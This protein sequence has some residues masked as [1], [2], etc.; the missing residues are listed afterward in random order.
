MLAPDTVIGGKYVIVRLLESGGM[1]DVYDAKQKDLGRPVAIKMLRADVLGDPAM[2]VR[3][4]R[5][6]EAAASLGHPN[7]VQVLDFR[8]DPDQPPMLI[9]EKLEGRSLRELLAEAG[10]L[11]PSRVAFIALQILSAL[12]AAHDAKIVH[13]DVKPA[14]IFILKTFAVRDFVKVLDFGVAKVLDPGSAAPVITDLGQVLGTASYMAPEQ[15]KGLQVDG[16][17]DLFAV[18]SILFEALSGRRPRELG[19]AGI[20]DVGMKPCLK[21]RDVAPSIDPLLA[22]VVDRALALDPKERFPTAEAMAKALAPFVPQELLGGFGGTLKMIPDTV[23]M[24]TGSEPTRTMKDAA[25][26]SMASAPPPPLRSAPLPPPSDPS[27][28]S[29][30]V[31]PGAVLRS[32]SGAPPERISLPLPSG[33]STP[34]VP[35]SHGHGP[36]TPRHDAPAGKSPRSALYAVVI[37]VAVLA[38][39]GA[40]GALGFVLLRLRGS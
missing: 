27:A 26:P 32:P 17:A 7:I 31:S 2:F 40:L 16:R 23:P 8:N 36:M 34:S 6:A 29:T 30:K 38:V 35:A 5:E 1:G 39:L 12:A 20:I 9:M 4:Q 25:Q 21:L 19:A 3:F 11:A 18:G 37:V 10:T 22:R 13:R 14:N 15:A 33:A 28:D 24:P